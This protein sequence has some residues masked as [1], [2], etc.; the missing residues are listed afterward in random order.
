MSAWRVS[1]FLFLFSFFWLLQLSMP[2]LPHSCGFEV[3]I[4][5]VLSDLG[6]RHNMGEIMKWSPTSTSQDN[7]YIGCLDF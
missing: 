2:T 7:I 1:E 5:C 4:I 6:K 3:V